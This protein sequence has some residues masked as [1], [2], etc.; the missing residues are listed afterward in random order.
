MADALLAVL[1]L[2]VGVWLGRRIR[3]LQLDARDL[4]L[5]INRLR[6]EAAH[7]LCNLGPSCRPR[8]G[9]LPGHHLRRPHVS[10]RRGTVPNILTI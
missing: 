6:D 2:G 3:A 9:R 4:L 5:A 7:R 8:R 1:V 10:H